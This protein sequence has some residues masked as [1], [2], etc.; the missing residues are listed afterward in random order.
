MSEINYSSPIIIENVRVH[1]QRLLKAGCSKKEAEEGK[2]PYYTVTFSWDKDRTDVENLI[3]D[4]VLHIAPKSEINTSGKLKASVEIFQDG[5]KS[6]EDLEEYNNRFYMHSRSNSSIPPTIVDQNAEV[7]TAN[8]SNK[9]F[10][11][12]YGNIQV[13]FYFNKFGKVSK[14]VKGFQ[15]VN[16]D[17]SVRIGEKFTESPFVPIGKPATT[18][19]I[20]ENSED[21]NNTS[22]PSEEDG[23]LPF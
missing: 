3:K 23:D 17:E 6:K 13:L 9:I 19:L 16:N 10:D 5:D 4:T 22:A 7:V 21:D 11:G 15:I 14:I 2:S 8:D 1:F 18:N 20:T 12:M